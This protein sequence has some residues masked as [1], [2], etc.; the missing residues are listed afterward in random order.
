M[1]IKKIIVNGEPCWSYD[2]MIN[3]YR[4][5]KAS[6]K[7]SRI[8]AIKKG[9]NFTAQ[10][11]GSNNESRYFEFLYLST[12]SYNACISTTWFPVKS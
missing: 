4:L 9:R 10:R 7:W 8:F 12:S 6:K 5:R 3:G 2:V 1:S 11:K